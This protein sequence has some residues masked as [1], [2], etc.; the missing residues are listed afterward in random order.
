MKP[1]PG[2]RNL[3]IIP[4]I[5]ILFLAQ[6]TSFAGPKIRVLENSFDFGALVQG[7]IVTHKF[8]FENTG[9]A[10]LIILRIAPS[11][12]CTIGRMSRD[13]LKPGDKGS[14]DVTF[15]SDRFTGKQNKSI[16]VSCNDPDAPSVQVAFTAEI[17][18]IFEIKPDYIVFNTNMDGLSTRE[19]EV[20][21][22][23]VNTGTAQLNYIDI[24][25]LQVDLT[26]DKSF[27]MATSC[28]KGDSVKVRIQPVIKGKVTYTQHGF[29]ELKLGY[30]DGKKLEKK[31][32][33]AIK[34]WRPEESSKN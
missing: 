16:T 28:G 32:G 11:C 23:I 19:K 31:I 9:T 5:Y 29:L 6:S 14:L 33:V 4:F 8:P 7:D 21:F 30:A 24:K 12:G 17:T 27:P 1:L 3:R 34:K 25:P 10:D 18:R 2:T 13:T 26:F 20:P 22:E 15:N